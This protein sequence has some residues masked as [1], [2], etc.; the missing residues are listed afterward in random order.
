MKGFVVKLTKSGKRFTVVETMTL[1]KA[2][3]K[4]CKS[5]MC[6]ILKNDLMIYTA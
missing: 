6:L 4:Y 1:R 5:K 2:K 3:I